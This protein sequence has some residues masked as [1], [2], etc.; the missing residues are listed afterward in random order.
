MWG[1]G[2]QSRRD[3]TARS[4]SSPLRTRLWLGTWWTSLVTREGALGWQRVI[5]GPQ[6]CLVRALGYLMWRADLCPAPTCVLPHLWLHHQ[7]GSSVGS[8][9]REA[10]SPSPPP[11]GFTGPDLPSPLD[12]LEDPPG[13]LACRDGTGYQGNGSWIMSS[14]TCFTAPGPGVPGTVGPAERSCPS[15]QAPSGEPCGR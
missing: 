9:P 13:G 1:T 5:L 7:S 14:A 3:Q 10:L 15:L 2:P 8:K 4:P 11:W 6:G 12:C